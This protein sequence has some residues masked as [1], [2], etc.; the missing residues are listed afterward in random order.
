MILHKHH[1]VPR[2]MG[3]SNHESNIV[4]L[5]VEE[6]AEAHRILYEE[7]GKW[8]DFVAWKALSGQVGKEELFR[9]IRRQANLGRRHSEETKKK[10][11]EA[12][13]RQVISEETKQ[14]KS[15]QQRG[16][17]PTWD[18][19]NNTPEAN[20]KRSKALFGKRKPTIMCPHCK[21]EGGLPQ[22]KQW[23]FENCKEKK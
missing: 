20:E 1:I 9:E 22:M 12:R 17:K 14:K 5:T 3:G 2:H 8:E 23:H 21:K 6:H 15:D 7:H 16:K 10:I 19:K 4:L 11:R 13:A 18:L